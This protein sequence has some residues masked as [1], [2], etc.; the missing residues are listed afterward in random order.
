MPMIDQSREKLASSRLEALTD[1]LDAREDK[2]RS[3]TEGGKTSVRYRSKGLSLMALHPGGGIARFPAATRHLSSSTLSLLTT[4]FLHNRTACSLV[5]RELSGAPV[6]MRGEV[7]AC[8]H[9]QHA[10]HEVVL[11]LDEEI[12]TSVFVAV[13][14]DAGTRGAGSADAA[15]APSSHGEPSK[16]GGPESPLHAR[17]L[18]VE[19]NESERRL[20]AHLLS[21][22]HAEVVAVASAPE[23][24]KTLADG[25][26]FDMILS[27]LNLE[28]GSGEDVVSGARDAGYTG[29]IL[30][31][32]GEMSTSRLSKLAGMNVQD[33]VCKPAT[34]QTMLRAMTD[35]LVESHAG[36]NPPKIYS[37]IDDAPETAAFVSDFIKRAPAL[38]KELDAARTAGD[39]AMLADAL[40]KLTDEAASNGF[41]R[42]ERAARQ[43]MVVVETH[44]DLSSAAPAFDRLKRLCDRL[45]VRSKAA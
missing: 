5:L 21:K 19:D 35:A 43:V 3:R 11:K 34:P 15:A 27:D 12:D 22:A 37:S 36:A 40:V 7:S 26:T 41:E 9:I 1:Q 33:V 38:A 23:A 32:T 6:P 30:I 39:S 29:P 25:G 42:L 28:N 31:I 8:R 20:Y 13:C 44:A 45:D 17:V 10:I 2:S 4:C 16:P 14:T 18:L 24:M